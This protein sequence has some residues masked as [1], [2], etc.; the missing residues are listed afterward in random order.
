MAPTKKPILKQRVPSRKNLQS[1]EWQKLA[2][3]HDEIKK[4][5]TTLGQEKFAVRAHRYDE[6]ASFPFENYD[7]MREA[8]LL[9]MTVPKS[10]GGLGVE[11]SE[12]MLLAAEMGRWCG[13]TCGVR[14]AASK[15]L[16][17]LGVA[18]G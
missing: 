3:S 9:A 4:V 18:V 15:K 13:A 7:D 10:S 11:Y 16:W 6:E 14:A 2:G 1:F 5:I 8:G 17:G 12:Y